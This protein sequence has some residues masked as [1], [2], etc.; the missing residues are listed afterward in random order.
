M[1]NEAHATSGLRAIALVLVTVMFGV[2]SAVILKEAALRP[3]LG[4]LALSGVFALVIA[5]NGARFLVWG[6]IHNRYPLS[7]SYPLTSM[8]FPLVLLLG[9][10]YGEPITWPK[11]VGVLLITGG[12][13]L[14][15]M[16]ENEA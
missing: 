7:L 3:N 16:E 12:T 2:A 11:I 13:A 4:R 8:F 6:Y 14:L 15:A 9:Y 1:T 10:F 5:V